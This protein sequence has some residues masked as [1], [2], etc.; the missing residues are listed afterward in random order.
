MINFQASNPIKPA[1][2]LRAAILIASLLCVS[3]NSLALEAGVR[4]LESEGFKTAAHQVSD[5]VEVDA[6]SQPSIVD[7]QLKLLADIRVH[8]A[9]ELERILK[10]VD[11]LADQRGSQQNTAPVVFLLH[12][13]EAKTLYKNNYQTHRSVVDL[14]AKLSAFELV[15]IRV[16]EVWAGKQGLDNQ[17]LQPFVDTVPYAPSERKRLVKEDGYNYF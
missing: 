12:G 1:A 9:E 6:Q 2:P 17:L 13:E 8:S 10:R 16:C 7:E 14:A 15:D 5:K 4:S 11:E 3:Q